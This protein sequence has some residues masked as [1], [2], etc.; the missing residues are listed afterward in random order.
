MPSTDIL[1]ERTELW[2]SQ[3]S[4]GVHAKA[5]VSRY[6]ESESVSGVE[7]DEVLGLQGTIRV[8]APGLPTGGEVRSVSYTLDGKRGD[9]AIHRTGSFAFGAADIER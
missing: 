9:E 8:S 1:M 5:R 7:R 3:D 6:E 4:A 2:I